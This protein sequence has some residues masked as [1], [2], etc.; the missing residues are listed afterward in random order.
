MFARLKTLAVPMWL[1]GRQRSFPEQERCWAS[2][3][4]NFSSNDQRHHWCAAA[5]RFFAAEK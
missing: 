4:I 1:H 2:P 5:K 3:P